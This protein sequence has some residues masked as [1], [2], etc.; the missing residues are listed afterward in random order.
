MTEEGPRAAWARLLLPDEVARR[1][2]RRAI[3]REARPLLAARRD[4]LL[5]AISTW[6]ATLSPIAAAITLVFAGLA[7]RQTRP[8]R[9]AEDTAPAPAFEELVEPGRALPS[10][11]E[12]DSIPDLDAVLTVIYES[13]DT[14]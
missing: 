13:E 14:R 4:G 5:D 7:L 10:A 1:R 11:F 6:A 3:M 8:T 12:G 9:M 2:L